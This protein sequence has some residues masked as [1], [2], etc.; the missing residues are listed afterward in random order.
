MSCAFILFSSV[1]LFGKGS[2][3]LDRRIQTIPVAPVIYL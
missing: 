1:F 3:L 2:A